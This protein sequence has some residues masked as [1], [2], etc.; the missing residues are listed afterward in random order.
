MH[1]FKVDNATVTQCWKSGKTLAQIKERFP[2]DDIREGTAEN[3][4]IEESGEF[5]N[6]PQSIDE[7]R[8]KRISEI[9]SDSRKSIDV[10]FVYDNE[11][12]SLSAGAQ[13]NWNSLLALHNAGLAPF[14]IEVSTKDDGIYNITDVAFFASAFTSVAATLSVGRN[15]K[16]KVKSSNEPENVV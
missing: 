11:T 12:F 10:G 4:Q 3:G 15:L 13:A 1:I 7:R 14:P 5:I 16:I 2:D 6:P 8:E 9:D